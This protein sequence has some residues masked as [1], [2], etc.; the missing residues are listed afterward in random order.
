MEPFLRDHPDERPIPLEKPLENV[1]LNIH[2]LIPT[3]DKRPPFL[4][5]HFSCEKGVASQEGFH[6][7]ESIK[8]FVVDILKYIIFGRMC[9]TLEL[10]LCI[11]ANVVIV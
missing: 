8:E 2:V 7:N 4:K 11:D 10:F 3:P 9:Q 6:C 5:G 1:N